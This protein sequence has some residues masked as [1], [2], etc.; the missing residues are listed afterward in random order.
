[1]IRALALLLASGCTPQGEPAEQALLSQPEGAAIS[2]QD[3]QLQPFDELR[4]LCL[5]DA[6]AHA[7]GSG[8]E[9]AAEAACAALEAGTWN[10][11]C[12][13][14]AGEELARAGELGAAIGHCARAGRFS[15][16]CVTHAGWALQ[17]EA[18][19]DSSLP[20]NEILPAIASSTS[21]VQ[22][23]AQG[24]EDS[25]R[26]EALGTFRM[27]LWY[28]LYF[29]T[30]VAEPAPA[31]AAPQDQAA[32]ARSAFAL[33]ASRLLSAP[34]LGPPD[35]AVQRIQRIWSGALAAP[36]GARLPPQS[37]HG[38]YN[39]PLPAPH[40]RQLEHI[41]LYGGGRRLLGADAE[42]DL[43][44]AALEAL[45]FRPD[46]PSE[47]Y[48]PWIHD[49]R[50]R[51]RWTA[52]RLLRLCQPQTL[53]MEATLEPLLQSPDPGLRWNAEDALAHRSW[54]HKPG[55]AR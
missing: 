19:F 2:A 12:H 50:D 6:A 5:V 8:D 38:R 17:P 49:P 41:P 7:A 40:E 45:Y 46:T 31:R 51:V 22:A 32:Q 16:F 35:D 10:Q 25:A 42:E 43:V 1:V 39:V 11:E 54:E 47:L 28:R 20:V 55:E 34:G 26:A 24:L 13:F 27:S 14:R 3:C 33:E 52:A 36:T 18:G 53:D 23:A 48:L 9:A 21:E 44:V 30:G 29:G 15:R 4:V 37:R